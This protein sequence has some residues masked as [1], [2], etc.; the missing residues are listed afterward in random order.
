MVMRANTNHWNW[1]SDFSGV[2]GIQ[3]DKGK[4]QQ[5]SMRDKIG[6]FPIVGNRDKMVTIVLANMDL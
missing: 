3:K 6:E 1:L 5:I 2:D 4:W